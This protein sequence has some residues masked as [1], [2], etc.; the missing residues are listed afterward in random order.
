MAGTKGAIEPRDERAW[1]AQSW[2]ISMTRTSTLAELA[3]TVPAAAQVFYRHGLDFCC[4]GRRPLDEACAARGIDVDAVLKDIDAESATA[5]SE[6]WDTRPFSEL[7]DRI[8]GFYHARLRQGLPELIAM[9]EKVEMRHAEKPNVP[10]GLGAL[11]RRVEADVLDHLA[12]EEQVLFP[13]I[14][15][16][17]GR[18]AV[19]PVHVLELEHAGHKE[20]LLA[21][22]ALTDGI[23]PP[24]HACVTWRALYLGLQQFEQELM[25]HIHLENN[26]LFQRAL[27]A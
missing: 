13:L 23:T 7:I 19:G 14:L 22:R 24:P 20:D 15:A 6:R 26:V 27:A 21:I 2:R 11:L 3:T 17:R 8:V 10:A 12:K 16:G 4:G 5:V 25:E 1:G 18:D 9:S